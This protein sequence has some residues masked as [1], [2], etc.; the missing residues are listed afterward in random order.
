[1][2]L[3]AINIRPRRLSLADRLDRSTLRSIAESRE[4]SSVV[5]V[6]GG[7]A[8]TMSGRMFKRIKAFVEQLQTKREALHGFQAD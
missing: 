6:P 2:S 3:S 4:F 1:M 8:D 5:F 7:K